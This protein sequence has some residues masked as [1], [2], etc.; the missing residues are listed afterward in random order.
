MFSLTGWDTDS[1]RGE[2]LAICQV[3]RQI[4][5]L[6][7]DD[8]SGINASVLTRY[9]SPATAIHFPDYMNGSTGVQ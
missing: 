8:T 9:G 2:R 1:I 5:A 4:W 6:V 3:L 7:L